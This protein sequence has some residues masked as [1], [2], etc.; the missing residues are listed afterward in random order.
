MIHL[1][2]KFKQDIDLDEAVQ[3]MQ[4]WSNTGNDLLAGMISFRNYYFDK[5]HPNSM[6]DWYDFNC[7]NKVFESVNNLFG[8]E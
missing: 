3:N 7:Y 5:K 1:P 6:S 4:W 8:G 2:K